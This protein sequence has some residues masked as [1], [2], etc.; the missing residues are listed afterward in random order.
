MGAVRSVVKEEWLEGLHC[1]QSSDEERSEEIPIPEFFAFF[2]EWKGEKSVSE[3]DE[4]PAE[5][6]FDGGAYGF[7]QVLVRSEDV[8]VDENG[9]LVGRLRHL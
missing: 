2:L 1:Q 3:F 9:V 7:L 4:D 8:L 5:V 6:S